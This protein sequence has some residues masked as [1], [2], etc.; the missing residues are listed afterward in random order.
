MPDEAVL[1]EFA[2]FGMRDGTLPRR[3]PNR[4]WG[5]RGVGALCAVCETPTTAE[6]VEYV[7]EFARDGPNS[8]RDRLLCHLRCFAMWELERTK[9]A[10]QP[11][12][13]VPMTT[14]PS[15][16]PPNPFNSP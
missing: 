11:D 3:E 15:P 13:D 1:R 9:P 10:S 6:Q 12:G 4:M 5:R 2:R 16:P 8:D 14:G 7:V